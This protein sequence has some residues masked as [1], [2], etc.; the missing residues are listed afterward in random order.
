MVY[1][2]W[3]GAVAVH[4][5]LALQGVA[6]GA[7]YRPLPR[8]VQMT[9]RHKQTGSDVNNDIRNLKVD[10]VPAQNGAHSNQKP[11]A[12]N[13]HFLFFGLSNILIAYGVLT[14]YIQSPSRAVFYGL[15]KTQAS[16]L[17]SS[18]GA[19]STCSRL[20]SSLIV[21][22]A[23]AREKRLLLFSIASTLGGI[24]AL[25][26]CLGSD[27]FVSSVAFCA[28]YGLNLGEFED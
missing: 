27:D 3:R 1:L 19:V 12:K 23:S 10:T 14:M 7:T 15:T 22:M 25:L 4:G 2:G 16:L 5:C 6:L 24:V 26:S 9:A 18:M 17:P 20:T 8:P 11:F 28:A 21:G 13:P